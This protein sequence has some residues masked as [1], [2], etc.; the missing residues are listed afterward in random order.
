MSGDAATVDGE[1]LVV[2]TST[3]VMGTVF[4]NLTPED[5]DDTIKFTAQWEPDDVTYTVYHYT[6]VL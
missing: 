6:K 3:G 4:K 2:P 5:L 1:D